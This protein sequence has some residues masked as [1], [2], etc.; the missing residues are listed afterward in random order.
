MIDLVLADEA[1]ADVDPGT[2]ALLD[3]WHVAVG[4]AL[5]AG[6]AVAT[7]VLVKSSIEIT[8]PASGTLAR[9]LVEKDATF[10]R[11]QALGQLAPQA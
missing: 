10:K 4:A 6:D 9:I 11:G 5:R 1:W 8:A 7:V 2:E 3:R